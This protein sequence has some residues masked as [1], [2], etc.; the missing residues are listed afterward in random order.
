MD[1][2]RL[3]RGM[4]EIVTITESVP[5]QFKDKCFDILLNALLNEAAPTKPPAEKKPAPDIEK[6]P[7]E[8]S[9]PP[10]ASN[11]VG[12]LPPL[13]GQ[14]RLFMQ[15]TNIS[16]A[17]LAKV[18]SY[19]DDRVNFV[20]EPKPANLSAGQIDWSLLSALENAINN[21]AFTVDGNVVKKLCDDK[22]FLDSKNFWATFSR[23]SNLFTKPLSSAEPRQTLSNE[24]QA[25]LAKL[26][27]SLATR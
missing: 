25:E 19:V 14:M 18:V 26:I 15:R 24:G 9:P 6:P 22:G 3:K 23:N 4:A 17:T 27:E 2:E 20:H 7:A 1:F 10:A 8:Q 12:A 13:K 11:V 21:N 16:D 5:E